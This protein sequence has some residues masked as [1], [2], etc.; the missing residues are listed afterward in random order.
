MEDWIQNFIVFEC[1]LTIRK[2]ARIFS[3][4]NFILNNRI[5]DPNKKWKFTWSLLRRNEAIQPIY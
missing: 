1:E 3:V 5:W 4:H 2:G